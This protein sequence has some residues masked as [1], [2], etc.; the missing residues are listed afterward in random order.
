MG[1]LFGGGYK[2]PEDWRETLVKNNYVKKKA[3]TPRVPYI[4]RGVQA[5]TTKSLLMGGSYK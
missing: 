1:G 5:P 2:P 4:L 3:T